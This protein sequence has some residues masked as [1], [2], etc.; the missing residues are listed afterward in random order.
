MRGIFLGLLVAIFFCG[1]GKGDLKA[2]RTSACSVMQDMTATLQKVETKE[3]LERAAPKLKTLHERLI[4]LVEKSALFTNES[5]QEELGASLEERQA[6]D[7]LKEQIVRVLEIG[8]TYEVMI[9]IQENALHRLDQIS[10]EEL[11]AK[12]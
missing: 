3:D 7:N 5:A 4:D 6:S 9:E 10:A 11:R 1:C 2:I 12:L 8:D